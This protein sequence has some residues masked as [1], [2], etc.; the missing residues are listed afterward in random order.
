MKIAGAVNYYPVNV[1]AAGT[2]EIWEIDFETA[3]RIGDEP[4]AQ[5]TYEEP[6]DGVWGPLTVKKGV[7]Y[8]FAFEHTQGS[9]HY[10]YREPFMA[11]NYF[12][13]LNTSKPGEL[14]GL[15]MMLTRTLNHASILITRDKE[16]WGDQG[17]NNDLLDI[18]AH[19][20]SDLNVLGIE[21]V[22]NRGQS[23]FEGHL[24]GL[25]LMDWGSGGH[26][27]LKDI[28]DEIE[29]G[30][31]DEIEGLLDLIFAYGDHELEVSYTDEAIGFF[32]LLPFMSGAD[33]FMPVDPPGVI[34]LELEPRG[35]GGAVQKINV[36]NLPSDQYT[37]SVHFRDFVRAEEP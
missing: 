37:I 34:T 11:D 27:F 26:T 16:F 5:F 31:G 13:R 21:N 10:F 7:S 22:A 15:G 30:L 28:A 14:I 6:G 9:K 1:G 29:E 24:S 19:G 17:E 25:F 35:G 33:L 18:N 12:I 32:G 3:S 4:V 2:L 20:I 36:P 8:E 23:G